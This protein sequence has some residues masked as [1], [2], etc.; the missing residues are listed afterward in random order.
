MGET[1]LFPPALC[2][3]NM[4]LDSDSPS[5]AKW[6]YG[7][8][9]LIFCQC[10]YLFAQGYWN[11]HGFLS[12]IND[13]G[14]FDQAI[15]NCLHG[16]SFLNT[17][18]FKEPVHW[19]SLHFQPILYLFVA[20]YAIVPSINWLILCQALCLSL[21][22]YPV[23]LA[24]LHI[25]GKPQTSFIWAMVY[26]L[27]PFIL[28]AAF[29]DF[30]PNCMAVPLMAIG[31]L[32][33]LKKRP[34]LLTITCLI[35][36]T[37]KEHYG[38][39]VGAFA[40][41][42]WIKNRN[43]FF[44]LALAST[45]LCTFLVILG[46]IMPHLSVSGAQIMLSENQGQLSRYAWLGHN[47]QTVL[48]TIFTRPIYVFHV[49]FILL[50][51]FTY[52][53]NLTGLFFFTSMMAPLL[54]LPA[55]SDLLANLL[56]ANMM[57]RLIISYHTAPLI[58]VFLI[59]AIEG[60]QKIAHRFTRYSPVQYALLFTIIPL[61]A[62]LLQPS[63]FPSALQLK[64]WRPLQR[65]NLPDQR[66]SNIQDIIATASLTVQ[67]N[68]G[69]HFS[70]R[71]HM[72]R[73]PEKI[74]TCRFILLHLQSPT[75]NIKLTPLDEPRRNT[76]TSLSHHLQMNPRT[77]IQTIRDLIQT[78]D[79]GIRYYNSPWLILEKGYPSANDQREMIATTLTTLENNWER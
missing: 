4:T 50:G 19:F 66:I 33:V 43:L 68:I 25:T 54:L 55:L 9:I 8:W 5:T 30:H 41:L 69:P 28:S 67:A 49:I 32:A 53:L 3:T 31:L 1:D 12:S 77:F 62:S 17:S 7:I 72:Y 10:L 40:L 29:W 48:H 23:F 44:S 22:A 2:Q 21:T 39:S 60:T 58:P 6:H 38:L 18:Q 63:L 37:I 65:V 70:H 36:L 27:N 51:G 61:T 47:V 45:G 59:A 34:F 64:M 11:H 57:P 13:S 74:G 52:L 79:Y 56:S 24:A 78:S 71:Q 20:L 26:L 15:W 14:C 76:L 16:S 35:L 75:T 46:V 73:F 42:Y